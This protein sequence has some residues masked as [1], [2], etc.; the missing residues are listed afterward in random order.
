VQTWLGDAVRKSA[1]VDGNARLLALADINRDFE[2]RWQSAMREYVRLLERTRIEAGSLPFGVLLVQHNRLLDG[3][4]RPV[5]E[6]APPPETD[7][8]ERLWVQRRQAALRAAQERVRGDGLMLNQRIWRLENDGLNQIRA[9]LAHAMTERTNAL[10]LARRLEDRLGADARKTR[11]EPERL[12]EMTPKQRAQSKQW[13]L[14]GSEQ[15]DKGIAYNAIRLARTELQFANHAV[16]TEIAKHNPAVTGRKVRLSPGHPKSDICDEL[17]AGGPYDKGKELIPAHPQCVTPGQMVRTERGDVPIEDVR[18]GDRVLTHRGRYRKV[19]AAWQRSHAATV[20]RFVTEQGCFEVTGNHPVLLAHGWVEAQS[21]EVGDQVAYTPGGVC[22]DLPVG[23][24]EDAP[25]LSSEPSIAAGVMIGI[26]RMPA[27]SIALDGNLDCDK[28]KVEKVTRDLML[29]RVDDSCRI[30]GGHESDFRGC[31]VR[32][33]IFPLRQQHGHEAGVVPSFGNRDFAGNVG[34]LCGVIE[35]AEIETLHCLTH[36]CASSS[37]TRAIIGSPC[38]GDHLT[39]GAH[40]DVVGSK[41]FA[42]GA[43]SQPVA[44]ENLRC[45]EPLH[46]VDVGQ[47]V[48]D[49][50]SELRFKTQGVKLGAGESVLGKM[51]ACDIAHPQPTHG[52]E[53]FHDNLLSLSPEMRRGAESGN[54]VVGRFM[55][56]AQALLHYTAILSIERTHYCGPVYNM[57]VAEDNSYTVNGAVVHNCMCRYF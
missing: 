29:A 2:G 24:P 40:G 8:I 6:A 42:Q 38:S 31:R 1:D 50:A 51:G 49:R 12:R 53:N 25:P 5:A 20:Y 4:R 39:P 33:S 52:A 13:L 27:D 10:A 14:R 43:V 23:V 45:L 35:A 56:P 46:D 11:W 19:V 36:L 9:E 7:V 15:P 26:R 18:V 16:A 37:G 30:K 57:T 48:C 28:S 3:L 54:P 47:K 34:A 21:V 55:T 17:A 41:H 22:P 32:K 44:S